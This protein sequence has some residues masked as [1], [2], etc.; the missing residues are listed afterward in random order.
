MVKAPLV[1]V[2]IPAYNAERTIGEAISSVLHGS[3][4]EF[5]IIVCDDASSD[6]TVDVVRSIR[7]VR[8]KLLRNKV[9][10]GEGATRDRAIATATGKWIAPLDADDAFA[11]ERLR[12][13]LEVAMAYPRSIVFDEVMICHDTASGIR[14]WRPSRS[15]AIYPGKA[16]Q[17]RR[18]QFADWVLQRR[19]VMQPI[20]PTRLIREFSLLHSDSAAGA[21]IG[22]RCRLL[23]RS[24]AELWYVPQALYLY[25]TSPAGMSGTNDRDNLLANELESA[26]TAFRGDGIAIAALRVRAAYS[27]RAAEYR[28]FFLQLS[29][30]DLIDAARLARSKPW[31]IGEFTRRAVERIP[32]HLSRM[33]K[34]GLRR[35]PK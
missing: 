27:R 14:P 31:V 20:I 30:F 35:K 4:Q 29:Q 24:K 18:V 7:D 2:I 15:K 19:L 10:M 1:S 16:D 5:E 13:L 12:T 8:I 34:R 21:D 25:R 33:A 17:V 28:A 22:F 26:V 3:F 11:A 6:R 23:G 32:Y 9:N